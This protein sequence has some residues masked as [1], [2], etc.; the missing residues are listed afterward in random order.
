MKKQSV[1][2]QNSTMA[3]GICLALGNTEYRKSLVY[4][5]YRNCL[6]VVYMKKKWCWSFKHRVEK[7]GWMCQ[8]DSSFIHHVCGTISNIQYYSIK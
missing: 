5:D 8:A 6:T 2:K 7:N 1:C 3:T 4:F